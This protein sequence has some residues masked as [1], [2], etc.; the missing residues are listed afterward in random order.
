MTGRDHP[1]TSQDTMPEKPG[2]HS[3]AV[4]GTMLQVLESLP[5]DRAALTACGLG[6]V[7]QRWSSLTNAPKGMPE[8]LR[9]QAGKVVAAWK[10]CIRAADGAQ[11]SSAAGEKCGPRRQMPLHACVASSGPMHAPCFRP[12][13]TGAHALG[14]V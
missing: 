6:K 8:D 5:M 9:A 3:T 1:H 12:C 2:T 11:K 7:L 14:P 4:S 13:S 10:A